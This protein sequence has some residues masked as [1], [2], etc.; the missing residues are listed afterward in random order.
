MYFVVSS[1]GLSVTAGSAMAVD[2]ASVGCAGAVDRGEARGAGRGAVRGSAGGSAL[3]KGTA[4]GGGGGT[5]SDA[6][7]VAESVGCMSVTPIAGGVGACN[8]L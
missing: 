4:V 5:S 7:T 2:F 6:G 3:T 8:V 1:Y